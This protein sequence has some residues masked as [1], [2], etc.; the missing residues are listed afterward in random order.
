VR[1]RLS[2]SLGPSPAPCARKRCCTECHA[3]CVC[4][5]SSI[6][7]VRRRTCPARVRRARGPRMMLRPK[8]GRAPNSAADDRRPTTDDR[9]LLSSSSSS[10]RLVRVC[11]LKAL[12]RIRDWPSTARR[13]RWRLLAPRRSTRCRCRRRRDRYPHWAH[14]RVHRVGR[15]CVTWLAVAVVRLNEGDCDWT[16]T[17]ESIC[18]HAGDFECACKRLGRE[19]CGSR[20]HSR[21]A[22]V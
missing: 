10:R 21:E 14:R 5:S 3:N 15:A 7:E 19:T 8:P 9:L 16:I 17:T 11:T 1:E 4:T 6:R 13:W 2:S 20:S 18:L 12:G 22:H